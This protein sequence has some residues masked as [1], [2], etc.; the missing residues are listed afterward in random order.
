MRRAIGLVSGLA[1]A[2][3]LCAAP[4]P[5]DP[6]GRLKGLA[7]ELRCLVC[8]NQTIGDSNAPLANDLKREIRT[9]IAAGR[10]DEEI[11]AYMVARYGDFVLYRPPVGAATALLWGG[12]FAL[13]AAGIAG[14]VLQARRRRRDE[15]PLSDDE[16]RRARELIDAGTR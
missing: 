5:V 14:L 8:Q 9:M 4:P 10:T 2:G 12:P 3:A 11:R 15:E 7:D 6:E 13:A 1:L 16:A